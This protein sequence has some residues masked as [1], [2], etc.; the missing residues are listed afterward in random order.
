MIQ[1]EGSWVTELENQTNISEDTIKENL[2]INW[3]LLYSRSIWER[4]V[5]T[6]GYMG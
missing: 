3:I 2:P 5:N 6:N 4:A 1:H